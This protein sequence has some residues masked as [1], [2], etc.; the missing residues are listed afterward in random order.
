MTKAEALTIPELQITPN[1]LVE[2]CFYYLMAKDGRLPED[3][4]RKALL[5]LQGHESD[6]CYKG[7]FIV[8][9]LM[10]SNLDRYGVTCA[11]WAE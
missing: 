7:A 9:R 6:P 5:R 1:G 8:A 2:D 10:I 4:A 11:A 3:H